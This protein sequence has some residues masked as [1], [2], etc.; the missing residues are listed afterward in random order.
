MQTNS[1]GRRNRTDVF[2]I[3]WWQSWMSAAQQCIAKD[4]KYLMVDANKEAW[5]SR[6]KRYDTL[7]LYTPK[8]LSSLRWL[9]IKIPWNRP[10]KN[11]MSRYLKEYEWKIWIKIKYNTRVNSIAKSNQNKFIISTLDNKSELV[12]EYTAKNI[13]IATWPFKDKH[14]PEF[15]DKLNPSIQQLHSSEYISPQQIKND[16][17]VVVWW[18]NSWHQISDELDTYW[19][20]VLYS[21]W[22]NH[23][24]KFN[25]SLQRA[26]ARLKF[27]LIDFTSNLYP[28]NSE[29]KDVL[30]PWQDIIF[31]KKYNNLIKIPY[32]I[33]A[34]AD[35]LKLS[36]WDFLKINSVVR[37][38]WYKNKY[39]WINIEGLLD[40]E[41]KIIQK[42][43]MTE[44]PW[45]YSMDCIARIDSSVRIARQIVDNIKIKN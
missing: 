29:S 2:I 18:W 27:N 40:E 42:N 36:S 17:V 11:D 20:K 12:T 8:W 7:K 44:V 1:I 35:W 25:T 23:K 19:K 28:C 45:I 24:Q 6:E 38:T 3:W 16:E 9:K 33:D 31:G 41:W 14:V 37:C 4:I 22:S 30:M 39:P 26:L 15:A 21:S 43:G 32:I 5:V 13:I 34:N 10:T